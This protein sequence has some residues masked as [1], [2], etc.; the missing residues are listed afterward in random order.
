MKPGRYVL[1]M[2]VNFF[3]TFNPLIGSINPTCFGSPN[4]Y[5][6]LWLSL[7][8][9]SPLPTENL[10]GGCQKNLLVF[11]PILGKMIHCDYSKA[12]GSNPP[13][14][15]HKKILP[16]LQKKE[17]IC[18][19][20]LLSIVLRRSLTK[21]KRWESKNSSIWMGT[22]GGERWSIPWSTSISSG[23]SQFFEWHRR[24]MRGIC[25]RA[26]QPRN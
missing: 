23:A 5:P 1:L 8:R 13:P 19:F 4:S 25:S 15:N 9:T 7:Q 3:T 20:L 11:T 17:N 6:F 16:P 10:G 21:K 14:K 2:A 18:N 12:G 26:K 22:F 24:F